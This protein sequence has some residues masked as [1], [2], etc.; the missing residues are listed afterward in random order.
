MSTYTLEKPPYGH[1]ISQTREKQDSKKKQTQC[2]IM[3]V[4]FSIFTE[5]QY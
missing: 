5:I 3:I 4:L 1:V 2:F